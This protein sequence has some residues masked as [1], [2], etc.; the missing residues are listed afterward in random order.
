MAVPPTEA[1]DMAQQVLLWKR[2]LLYEKTSKTAETDP[3]MYIKRLR[4]TFDSCLVVLRFYP[5]VWLDYA[6][7]ILKVCFLCFQEKKICFKTAKKQ[8]IGKQSNKETA[9]EAARKIFLLAMEA[10]PG[11]TLIHFEYSLF[12]ERHL[13]VEDAIEVFRSMMLRDTFTAQDKQL[14]TI[15]HLLLIRRCKGMVEAR[16][17]MVKVRSLFLCGV[18]PPLSWVLFVVGVSKCQFLLAVGGGCSANGTLYQS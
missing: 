9:L 17:F 8:V 5:E 14:A 7:T 16:T 2:L 1:G 6:N 10:L 15:H 4:A 11:S 12:L 3:L 18:L 13:L